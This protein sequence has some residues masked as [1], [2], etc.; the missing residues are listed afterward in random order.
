MIELQNRKDE[1]AE[2]IDPAPKNEK[3]YCMRF[4]FFLARRDEVQE[5]LLYYP[6][7]RRWH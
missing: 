3:T 1:I 2:I 4:F 6:R 5:E 7:H